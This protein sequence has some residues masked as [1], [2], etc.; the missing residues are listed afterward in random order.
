[1]HALNLVEHLHDQIAS[2]TE[3]FIAVLQEGLIAIERRCG[4]RLRDGT[5]VGGR[6][7]LQL[8]H[9]LDQPLRATCEPNAPAGHRIGL[10]TAIDRQRAIIKVWANLQDRRERCVGIPDMFIH[11]VG[12]H[13]HLRMT[14]EHIGQTLELRRRIGSP[15]RVGRR[16]EQHPTRF[17]RDRRFQLGRRDLVVLRGRC[18][19]KHRRTARK[20]N[21]IRITDP[22]RCGDDHFIA[23]ID[24][25]IGRAHV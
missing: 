4:R 9:R 17:G 2:A 18:C 25:R 16:V 12:Q 14:D 19:D 8:C 21:D 23:R 5:G 3:A 20:G 1:M 11:I 10:G 6:L 15:R 7:R 24:G 22:I 13:H